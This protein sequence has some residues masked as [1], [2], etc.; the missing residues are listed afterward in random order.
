M[1]K[2]CL[3]FLSGESLI[4]VPLILVKG[5]YD[6]QQCKV[7]LRASLGLLDYFG[8]GWGG[9]E[10]YARRQRGTVPKAHSLQMGGTDAFIRSVPKASIVCSQQPPYHHLPRAMLVKC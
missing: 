5:E 1:E 4:Y 3:W 6:I 9:G 7:I 10:T 8:G 2:G